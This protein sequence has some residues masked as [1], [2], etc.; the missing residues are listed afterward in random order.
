MGIFCQS[1][2]THS[3]AQVEQG[4][5]VA[6]VPGEHHVD[7]A[8]GHRLHASVGNQPCQ[9]HPGSISDP[10]ANSRKAALLRFARD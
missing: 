2:A 7:R 9:T 4:R 8:A 3:V 10:L 5:E 6:P 1:V